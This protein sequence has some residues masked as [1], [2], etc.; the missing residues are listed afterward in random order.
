MLG[1]KIS[2]VLDSFNVLAAQIRNALDL[3][4]Q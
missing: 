1:V 2:Y 4:Q 3:K